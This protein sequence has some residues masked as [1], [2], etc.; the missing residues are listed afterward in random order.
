MKEIWRQVPE[1]IANRMD[2]IRLI[3]T[4]YGRMSAA[5]LLRSSNYLCVP[6]I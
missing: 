6:L 4:F 5:T 2:E 3:T 1:E